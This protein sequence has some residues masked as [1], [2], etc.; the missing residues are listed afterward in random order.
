MR[1][2]V[3]GLSCS[4]SPLFR[5]VCTAHPAVIEGDSKAILYTGDIRSEPWHV[6][7]LA[8]NPNLIEYTHG[9]KA[10]DKVYLDTSFTDDVPF[11]T[12]A[13]GLAELLRQ[14][15]RYPPDTIF[16]LQAWTFGYE[17]V[18]VALSRALNSPVS[19]RLAHQKSCPNSS[20]FTLMST[21]CAFTTP[22]RLVPPTAASAQPC[23]SPLRLQP[24]RDTSAATPLN[25]AA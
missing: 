23:I 14:V 16:N 20:R 17:D 24:S 18:W 7:S 6:N 1:T 12:K 15:S 9:I 5:R 3:L 19:G 2:T 25:Q 21:R 11:Q 4:V 8:R 22:S 13:E 10:L